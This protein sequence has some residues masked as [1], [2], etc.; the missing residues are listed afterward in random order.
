MSRNPREDIRKKRRRQRRQVE[1]EAQLEMD[2][3]TIL[4]GV[5]RFV[6]NLPKTLERML[7]SYDRVHGYMTGVE[8][9]QKAI[10]SEA[11]EDAARGFRLWLISL[12]APSR[13]PWH[14]AA[15]WRV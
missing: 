5:Q 6:K 8:A 10:I 15:W 4:G 3:S 7:R 2:W 12:D 11:T 14:A 1:W 13:S 9:T